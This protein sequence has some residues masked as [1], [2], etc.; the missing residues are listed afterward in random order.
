[1]RLIRWAF[2]GA[3]GVLAAWSVAWAQDEPEPAAEVEIG[4]QR[5]VQL[6]PLQMVAEAEKYVPAMEQGQGNV[7]RSLLEARAQRDVV[8][9]LCLSDKLSQIDVAIK[10]SRDRMESLRGAASEGDEDR[11]KHEFTVLRVLRDRVNTLVSEAAQCI[12]EETGFVGEAS[13]T[14][15]ID[16]DMPWEDPSDFPPD[17]FDSN[18]PVLSSP[19]L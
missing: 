3:A 13:V 8:K 2:V 19:F 1:V 17:D 16:P 4:T 15:D 18:P 11:A 14:V 12:G 6:T 9:V 7:K 5:D 10:S